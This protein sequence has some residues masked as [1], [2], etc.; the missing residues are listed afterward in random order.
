MTKIL[1]TGAGGGG[2]EN[3]ISSLRSSSLDLTIYGS[4]MNEYLL[5]RTSADYAAHLPA[6][7]EDGY[8]EAL[9]K[10]LVSEGIELVVPNNDREVAAISRHR[11]KVACKVFLPPDET[12]RICH[13]K[14][15]MHECFQ[16][17]DVPQAKYLGLK[18][19]EDIDRFVSENPAEKY[20]VRPRCGS[21]S[22]GATWVRTGQQAKDWIGLWCDL[23]GYSL[24]DFIIS[25]F[26]PGRDYAFQSVWKDGEMVVGKMVE[27]LSYI[28]AGNRLSG[29]GSSP[30]VGRTLL[31]MK[32]YEESI[33]KAIYAVCA[34]PHGNFNLDLKG[35]E[36]SIMCVT[37][38]N[39]GRFCMITP[40][41]DRTGKYNTAEM[42]VRSALDMEI[43][44]DDPLD[45]ED[46][47]YLIRFLDTEPTILR[48]DEF[49]RK[50]KS[51]GIL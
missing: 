33:V 13:D 25:E 9:N 18:S 28:G 4:N 16:K 40:I 31:D 45:Y 24:A 2:G 49:K 38:F 3:L 29:M 30:A 10:L 47:C 42:H 20:W 21:G 26:L 15:E 51:F 1:V 48:A 32:T 27:R 36:D 14:L 6:A 44:V 7:T 12:V 37:E 34:K 35:R 46:G 41:F 8:L 17:Y 23:R 5:S 19:L 50:M 22:R 43:N 39:I 11:E